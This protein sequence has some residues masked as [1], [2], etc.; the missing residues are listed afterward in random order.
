MYNFS[1]LTSTCHYYEDPYPPFYAKAD[2]SMDFNT[3]VG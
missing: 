3:K 1:C 2:K